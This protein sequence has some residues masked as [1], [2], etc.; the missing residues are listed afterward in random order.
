M[1]EIADTKTL[2]VLVVENH[3]DTL[4][5]L[6]AYLEDSGHQVHT[7]MT[8]NEALRLLDGYAVDVL[9]CD[10]GLPDGTGWDLMQKLPKKIFAVAMSGFGMNADAVKSRAAGF[11]HHLLK[12]FKAAELDRIL[13]EAAAELSR[14]SDARE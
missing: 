6:K 12:P 10:I 5:T 8:I 2:S 7:A 14:S 1:S 4:Q 3:P 9:L 11:R 13:A